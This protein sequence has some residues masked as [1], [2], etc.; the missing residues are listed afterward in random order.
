MWDLLLPQAPVPSCAQDNSQGTRV[1]I[2]GI[3]VGTFLSLSFSFS[4]SVKK[5]L[6]QEF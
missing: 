2:L 4:S 5:K 6:G 1:G 3:Q